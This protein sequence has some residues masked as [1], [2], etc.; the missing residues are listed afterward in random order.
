MIFT[1]CLPTLLNR[2]FWPTPQFE[3]LMGL[4]LPFHLKIRIPKPSPNNLIRLIFYENVLFSWLMCQK[5]PC[6]APA[7]HP[8]FGRPFSPCGIAFVP[9]KFP[10]Y[11]VKQVSHLGLPTL[12]QHWA[13][14]PV[15]QLSRYRALR[16]IRLI[17][18]F[19]HHHLKRHQ[20]RD[21]PNRPL[22]IPAHVS[23]K[24]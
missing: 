5:A 13:N 8:V 24:Q 9:Q 3:I 6:S 2:A 14:H 20:R 12:F 10:E 7:N 21:F 4:R 17:K 19:A 15:H 11:P 16:V 18:V 23:I 22:F 1:Q